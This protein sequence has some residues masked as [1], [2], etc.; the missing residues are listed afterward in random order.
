MR[1]PLRCGGLVV[2]SVEALES[3]ALGVA[4]ERHACHSLT[5]SGRFAHSREYLE[6]LAARHGFAVARATPAVLRTDRDGQIRG[7]LYALKKD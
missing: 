7:W 6:Q 3:A 5:V 4:S 1:R 2:F